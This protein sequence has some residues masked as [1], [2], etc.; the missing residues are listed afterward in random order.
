MSTK[1]LFEMIQDNKENSHLEVMKKELHWCDD[2]IEIKCIG[3]NSAKKYLFRLST[4]LISVMVQKYYFNLNELW[5]LLVNSAQIYVDRVLFSIQH[6]QVFPL[7][8]DSQRRDAYFIYKTSKYDEKGEPWNIEFLT[9]LVEPFDLEIQVQLS[10][11]WERRFEVVDHLLFLFNIFLSCRHYYR[12]EAFLLKSY[13]ER[14]CLEKYATPLIVA[15]TRKS[16][17]FSQF[18]KETNYMLEV[19]VSSFL[20]NVFIVWFLR[21]L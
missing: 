1:L 7:K 14:Y 3:I 11:Y 10:A 18:P 9:N 12:I 21:H 2:F 4:A 19:T 20:L 13:F 15:N 8:K 5:R 17:D 16:I 6:I